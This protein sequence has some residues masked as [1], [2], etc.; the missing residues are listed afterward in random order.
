MDQPEEDDGYVF[1][2]QTTEPT[3]DHLKLV[4][5]HPSQVDP[6]EGWRIMMQAIATKMK[7]IGVTE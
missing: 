7:T 2:L 5:L 4:S 3:A 6:F 1:V